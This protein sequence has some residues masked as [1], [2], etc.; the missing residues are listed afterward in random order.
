MLRKSGDIAFGV[1]KK[2]KE[3]RIVIPWQY[4]RW[5]VS[6]GRKEV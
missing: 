1:E 2:R 6:L 5:F 4:G 3:N